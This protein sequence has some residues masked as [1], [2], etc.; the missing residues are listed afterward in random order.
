MFLPF[1]DYVTCKKGEELFGNFRMKPNDRNKRDL[2]FEIDVDFRGE[3]C[4]LRER[5]KYRM[6]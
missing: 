2:D 5:N 6:R 1:Q 3:L 4:E